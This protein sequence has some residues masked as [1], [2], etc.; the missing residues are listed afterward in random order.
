ELE[1]SPAD[2]RSWYFPRETSEPI[3]RNHPRRDA[4]D[5]R[6]SRNR[7]RA[8][9]DRVPSRLLRLETRMFGWYRHLVRNAQP[10]AVRWKRHPPGV[11]SRRLHIWAAQMT[12]W[13]HGKRPAAVL[14]W[15]Y[16][17]RA[18]RASACPAGRSATTLVFVQTWRRTRSHT[19][20]GLIRR[21][22]KAS[23]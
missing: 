17:K 6:R 12:E 15:R 3:R 4:T 18:P 21:I 19:A 22:H 5:P 7:R 20:R 14:S 9:R 16:Q 8:R 23:G 10:D 1:L 2:G 11:N 13:P